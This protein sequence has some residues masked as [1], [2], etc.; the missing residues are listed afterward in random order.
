MPFNEIARQTME[1]V[2]KTLEGSL[3]QETIDSKMTHAVEGPLPKE[4]N[5]DF[6]TG[7]MEGYL[8][9]ENPA[10]IEQSETAKTQEISPSSQ[11][12]IIYTDAGV[13][14]ENPITENL[15]GKEYTVYT[16]DIDPT[17][18]C[19]DG[20]TNAERMSNGEA[21]Y[22]ERNGKLEKITLHH[23]EQKN[24]VLVEL[25]QKTHQSNNEA[26]HPHYGAGEGRGEDPSWDARREEHWKN[27]AA[28]LERQKV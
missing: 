21:P 6:S 27:R 7:N 14:L 18:E 20:R 9:E 13:D 23:H 16:C 2:S 17:L 5:T 8:P 10:Q 28:E 1:G 3:P 12:G 4:S 26:L 15:Q 25:D 22:V 19:P 24:D 11:E